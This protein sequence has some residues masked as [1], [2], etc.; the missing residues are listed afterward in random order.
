MMVLGWFNALSISCCITNAA[1]PLSLPL[2]FPLQFTNVRLCDWKRQQWLQ[3]WR[4]VGNGGQW[5]R[6]LND[7][8]SDTQ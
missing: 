3:R 8:E 5:R 4:F 2:S 1:L 7:R 6:L